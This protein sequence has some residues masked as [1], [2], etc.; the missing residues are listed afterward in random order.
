MAKAGNFLATPCLSLFER[1]MELA[2]RCSKR[3]NQNSKNS[4]A[5]SSLELGSGAMPNTPMQQLVQ[6]AYSPPPLLVKLWSPRS[7]RQ[8]M[9]AKS[10]CYAWVLSPVWSVGVPPDISIPCCIVNYPHNTA[11]S[12]DSPGQVTGHF[13]WCRGFCTKS[14]FHKNLKSTDSNVKP[15]HLH[16]GQ[17]VSF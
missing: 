7:N 13:L 6:V 3:M 8:C 15:K 5:S 9:R 4:I 14:Q 11:F 2:K 1:V 17:R 16:L 12:G 10:K